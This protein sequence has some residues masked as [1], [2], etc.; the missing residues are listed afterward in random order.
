M[1]LADVERLLKA[2]VLVA[3]VDASVEIT[4]WRSRSYFGCTG[5]RQGTN[6]FAY[7]P[8][9]PTSGDSG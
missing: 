9:Q 1:K 2:E 5:I 6:P 7:R 8:Y 4:C 3:P